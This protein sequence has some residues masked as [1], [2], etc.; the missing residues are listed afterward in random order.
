MNASL[1]KLIE[2]SRE[3][4]K[5]KDFVLGG[6]GNTSFKDDRYLWI[7]A[8]GVSLA[9]ITE[10]G[11]VQLDRG[12]LAVIAEAS[13][14]EDSDERERQ[15]MAHLHQAIVDSEKGK[16][17]SV[18]TS[19]HNLIAYKYVVHMHP[20]LVNA[21]LCARNSARISQE[22]FGNEALYIGYTDPG[23]VL[24]KKLSAEIEK[25]RQVHG[26]DPQII[27]LENHG[28]FISADTTEEIRKLYQDV[29]E[30]ISSKIPQ[31]FSFETLEV[32]DLATEVLPVIRMA[33][34]EQGLKI[35][36]IRNNTLIEHFAEDQTRF[37]KV[38]LPFTPDQIVYCKAK[39]IY[40]PNAHTAGEVVSSFLHQLERFRQEFGY[41][42]KIILIKGMG[43]AA[44]D[45]HHNAVQTALDVY[46][47]LM[48]ISYFS[49][50]F[51]GP[52]FMTMDQISFIDHWEVENYRRK[53]SISDRQGRLN[54]KIALV[55]GA[56]QGFGNGIARGLFHENA[57]VVIADINDEAGQQLADELNSKSGK[58]KSLFVHADVSDPESVKK[59]IKSTVLAFGG[60]DILISNAGILQA[61]SLDEMEPDVFERITRINYMGYYLC[62]KYASRIMKIQ[63]EQNPGHFMDIMQI[64]SKSG[65][66]G[67]NKNFAYAGGKFGGIGLTESF[68]LELIPYR[69]KVNSI[70]PGNFFE[71]PLW[72]D[73]R[74]GL[75]VQYLQAG[76]V[77]GA[78]T[79]DDVKAF[80]EQ[81]VPAGR[82]CRVEDVMKAILYAIEQEYETGQ[83]I[84][85]TGGQVML[86]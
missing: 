46:E 13:Y 5:N 27:L 54:G 42:P 1:E 57:H 67:S 76:K 18:E 53:V 55:T 71:G 52:R 63:H 48:K 7:K 15:V 59:M 16:R 28:I 30:R 2:I 26:K 82:G 65:L 60:I 75:F 49:E 77:P 56:A 64:N 81:Q 21:L 70:C 43:L 19:L 44:V 47:D 69:I 14:I 33:F 39:Y 50:F 23:Y 79:I 78:R 10:E 8:S 38:S 24:F 25:Y 66:R 32:S 17:P 86:K 6:G 3:Y 29:F 36:S 80:Y 74:K 11:F 51:G 35:V 61:G 12:K 58:N 83:A 4:G 20:W 37:Q 9:D 68:A 41:D 84:P 72:S 85:V 40:I 34:S 31:E 45:A 73:P 22:L 62:A